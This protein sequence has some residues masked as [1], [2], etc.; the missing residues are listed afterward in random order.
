LPQ[1]PPPAS[2]PLEPPIEPPAEPPLSPPSSPPLPPEENSTSTDEDASSQP[3]SFGRI[4]DLES[5]YDY[6]WDGTGNTSIP[7]SF[8]RR[9]RGGCDCRL[10]S[11]SVAWTHRSRW[12]RYEQI[13]HDD[14]NDVPYCLTTYP[15]TGAWEAH[16]KHGGHGDDPLTM[17][18]KG[19]RECLV[20]VNGGE[21]A[22][23][24]QEENLI[25]EC[26][27]PNRKSPD[28][29]T[30]TMFVLGDSH[31]SVMMPALVHAARGVFQVRLLYSDG[32]GLF[33]HRAAG[34][35]NLGRFADVYST[36]LKTLNAQMTHGDAVVIAMYSANW[37]SETDAISRGSNGAVGNRS[38]SP[39]HSLETDL[40]R[41]IIEPA[42]S[43]LIVFG[44]WPYYGHT[45][46][47]QPP[48][49]KPT[50]E[51]GNVLAQSR[52]HKMIQPLLARHS[53]LRYMPLTPLFCD[54]DIELESNATKLGLVSHT[55]RGA[56]SWNIPGTTVP[57]YSD[58]ENLNT[59]GSIY[60]WPYICDA[61]LWS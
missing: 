45:K 59:V 19:R 37:V 60:M 38:S 15:A 21:G 36:I 61:G 50:K 1:S 35:S 52:L 16:K 7:T 32:V 11:N 9:E 33:P 43:Q 13:Q 42:K 55:P 8:G 44:D 6:V 48:F 30:R 53:A 49:G 12:S 41:G 23:T 29:P 20:S 51:Q 5:F 2:P 40:M 18:R 17:W 39:L 22:L 14:D 24:G 27:T 57:A 54:E 10:P 4:Q 56:C 47:G 58:G 26:L 34:V 3:S 46:F 25:T 31:A 28:H